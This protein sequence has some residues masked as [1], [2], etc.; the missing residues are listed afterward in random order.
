M[1]QGTCTPNGFLHQTIYSNR[2]EKLWR[3]EVK[4]KGLKGASV[5]F[6][7]IRMIRRRLI[8]GALFGALLS[9]ATFFRSVSIYSKQFDD[10]YCRNY[11]QKHLQ[12]ST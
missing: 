6:T 11:L 9:A 12:Y 10:K 3:E 1:S 8:V 7:V 5:L 2:F 4:R